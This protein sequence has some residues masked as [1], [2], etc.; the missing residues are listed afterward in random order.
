MGAGK[1]HDGPI[2]RPQAAALIAICVLEFKSK[3]PAAFL[4]NILVFDQCYQCKSVVSF[5]FGQGPD[6]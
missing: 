1:R 4:V 5:V 3:V 2:S 6:R